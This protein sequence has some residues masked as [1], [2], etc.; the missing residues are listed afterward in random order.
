MPAHSMRLPSERTVTV[1]LPPGYDSARPEPYPLLVLHD[2]QNLFASREDARGGSWH[3]DKTID[4]LVEVGTIPPVVLLAIDHGDERRIHEF[5]PTPGS[6]LAGGGAAEYAQLVFES[7]ASV[8]GEL[9]VRTDTNG[10][11]LGGSSLG[12]LV[13][14]WMASAF[15]GRFGRLMVMSPSLWW[16]RRMMLRLLRRQPIE[17]STTIWL[18]AGLRERRTVA[19]D[20]RA[21][22]DLFVDQGVAA[23]KYVEDPV[24]R[25]DEASWGR[26][27]GEALPRHPRAARPARGS[28]CAGPQTLEDPDGRHD[29]ASWGRRLVEALVWLYGRS[30]LMFTSHRSPC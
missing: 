26:R 9:H 13:T 5:T 29:E 15:P 4:A 14:L 3:A 1:H 20:T 6:D 27:F 7:I 24:G 18:D 25:H 17:P 28:G 21:L 19:R 10:L 22:R 23:L 16:D 8:A 12:G 11:A 30:G 2:G